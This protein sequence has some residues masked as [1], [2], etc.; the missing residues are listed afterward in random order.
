[1]KNL[2]AQSLARLARGVPKRYSAQEL[3][4]RSKRL[5]D[6]RLKRWQGHVKK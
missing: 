5:A 1:M 3:A 2:A 4:L 6:A